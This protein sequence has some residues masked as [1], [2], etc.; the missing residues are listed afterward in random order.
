MDL[1]PQG[2]G[3]MEETWSDEQIDAMFEDDYMPSEREVEPQQLQ[4]LQLYPLTIAQ[5]QNGAAPQNGVGG[6]MGIVTKKMGPL[7]VWAWTLIA[8]GVGGTGYLLYKGKTASKPSDDGDEDRSSSSPSV[9]DVLMN[10]VTGNGSAGGW[11]PSRSSFAQQLQ[12]YFDKKGQSAHVVVWVDAEDAKSQGKLSHVS[13]LV[14]V[15][16]KGGGVKADAALVRFARRDGLN[17]VQHDDG[18][19]GFYPHSTKRGKEWEGYI[20]ALRDEGQNV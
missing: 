10:A 9:G 4:P 6:I 17:P 7:P 12:R 8:A 19:I 3:K 2:L 15:Q 20:D 14:N 18:S 5:P 13:P 1:Q 16:V 11:G